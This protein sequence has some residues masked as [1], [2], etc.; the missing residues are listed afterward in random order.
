MCIVTFYNFLKYCTTFSFSFTS[1]VPVTVDQ[2]GDNFNN[3]FLFI[4]Y[5]LDRSITTALKLLNLK[6]LEK[7]GL[8]SQRPVQMD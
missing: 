5:T 8:V 1:I 3:K 6:T 7:V 4:F 2:N